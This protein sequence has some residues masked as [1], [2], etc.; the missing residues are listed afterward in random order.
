MVNNMRI[1]PHTSRAHPLPLLLDSIHGSSLLFWLFFLSVIH[2]IYEEFSLARLLLDLIKTCSLSD[3]AIAMLPRGALGNLPNSTP[4]NFLL[5]RSAKIIRHRW[6]LVKSFGLLLSNYFFHSNET[7][8]PHNSSHLTELLISS[9]SCDL[10]L[11]FFLQ[12]QQKSDLEHVNAGPKS[13]SHSWVA[14]LFAQMRNSWSPQCRGGNAIEFVLTRNWNEKRRQRGKKENRLQRQKVT[15]IAVSRC[16]PSS[17]DRRRATPTLK[18]A[19]CCCRR[20]SSLYRR[21]SC[22]WERSR[23]AMRHPQP[24]TNSLHLTMR[25]PSRN[26]THTVRLLKFT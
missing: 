8:L 6:V 15:F 18:N 9:S 1:A 26:M 21:F 11:L 12:H 22:K 14:R 13:S 17:A 3:R 10:W 7:D 4:N 25:A 2:S 16:F 24:H 23:H 19:T 5:P 20:C